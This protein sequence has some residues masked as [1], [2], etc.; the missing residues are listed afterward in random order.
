MRRKA[1]KVWVGEAEEKSID[2]LQYV[3]MTAN[4][5]GTGGGAKA[6]V[7]RGTCSGIISKKR[8]EVR[9]LK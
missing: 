5:D 2:L 8:R 6:A 4:K 1:G 7:G 3:T 9:Q